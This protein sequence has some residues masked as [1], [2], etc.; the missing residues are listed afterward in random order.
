MEWQLRVAAQQDLDKQLKPFLT[1]RR[2]HRPLGGWLRTVRKALGLSAAAMAKD[3]RVSPSAVFQMERAEWRDTITLKRLE[4]AARAMSCKLV[5]C[6]VPYEG[7][8]EGQGIMYV[9]RMLWKRRAARRKK[10]AR[11]VRPPAICLKKEEGG[12]D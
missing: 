6:V 3:L 10:K 4:D 5:Y 8:F 2:V 12:V 11:R 7:N 9:K 1:A